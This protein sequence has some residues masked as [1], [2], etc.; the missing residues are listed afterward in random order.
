MTYDEILDI[1][2][3][4]RSI[5]YFS[6]KKMETGIVKKLIAAARLAPSVENI[7]P[8]RFHIIEN[9]C[10]KKDL[11]NC[12]CYG[13]FIGG[14]S[15]FIVVT[16]DRSTQVSSHVPIWNPKEMEYSCAVAMEN[17]MIAAT[18]L[19]IGTCWVSLHHG[20]VHNLLKLRDHEVVVGGL[21]IGHLKESE[22]EASGDH[23]RR[24]IEQ[25]MT[26]HQ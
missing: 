11:M 7:Q 8:W 18:S 13:N 20:P 21:L 6:T 25:F 14:A 2:Q 17:M 9:E 22:Y 12:A 16:C 15:A 19:G 24:P 1:L 23:E 3:N 26:V 5:R 4:R 10:L